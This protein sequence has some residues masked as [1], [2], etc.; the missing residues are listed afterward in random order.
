MSEK[1][2]KYYYE[3]IEK[4]LNGANKETYGFAPQEIKNILRSYE[5]LQNQNQELNKHLEVPEPCNL[6]TLEDYKSYYE[7]TTKEQILADTYIDYC[8]YVNLAHRYAELKKQLEEKENIARNWKDS[9]LENAGKIEKLE[10]QQK[11]FIEY[12][13]DII[14]QNEIVVEVSKYGLPKN[15]SK[16]L[17]DF[18]KVILS[19]YKE[20]IGVSDDSKAKV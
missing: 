12:L 13:E 10:N 1:Q 7:D 5:E 14:K 2:I 6:K 16:L 11:E 8:A 9:C 18:Y 20:I 4:L 19:K 15:C 17:I 3:R